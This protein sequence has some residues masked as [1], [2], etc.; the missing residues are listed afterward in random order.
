ME[1]GY[2][3]EGLDYG[4]SEFEEEEASSS[5]RWRVAQG[6]GGRFVSA[7]SSSTSKRSR[8]GEADTTWV[9]TEEQPGG[10]VDGSVIP[11]F[12]GHV[13]S[14]FWKGKMRG[15]LKCQN[16]YSVCQRLR[17]WR[18]VMSPEVKAQIEGTG[19]SHLTDTMFRHIDFPLISAFVERWQPDTNS[20]HLKF[21]EMTIMLHDVWR[22][23][24]I[25]VDGRVV[26]LDGRDVGQLKAA[27]M[28]VLGVSMEAL[29]T[30]HWQGGGVLADSVISLLRGGGRHEDV[31]AV[32]WIWV[33]LG[34]TLFVDKSG[35]RI[36]PSCL[37][38]VIDGVG[39]AHE[40]SWGSA[41]LAY[42]Y[43]QLGVAS[44]GDSQG[45]CGCLTLLQ[46]WIYEYFPCFR[47]HRERMVVGDGEAPRACVWSAQAEGKDV[48]R[49]HSIRRRLDQLTASEVRHLV[50]VLFA[51]FCLL[52][53]TSTSISHLVV[54]LGGMAAVRY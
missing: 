23:L 10:P 8:S 24:R 15:L 4:S 12:L 45:I 35:N 25:P 6:R 50:T 9:V 27:A 20:F 17:D 48:G 33:L 26:S 31:E 1:R 5:G 34:A 13:A 7:G 29:M 18:A 37:L 41:A 46:A 16:R 42:L 11:S 22:I 43:R 32:G 28:E 21:G 39:T 52:R 49:L 19:L 51:L 36:R 30:S 44:R 38:E 3:E 40:Y 47:P 54:F 2:E 14:Y 53:F